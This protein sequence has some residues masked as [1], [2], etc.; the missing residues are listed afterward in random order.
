[1]EEPAAGPSHSRH[2]AVSTSKRSKMEPDLQ[3]DI[4]LE[5]A[6]GPSRSRHEMV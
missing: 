1:M 2:Q 6:A 3:A 5:P 4:E